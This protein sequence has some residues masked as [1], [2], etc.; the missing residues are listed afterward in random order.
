M[1]MELVPDSDPADGKSL[2]RALLV[3]QWEIYLLRL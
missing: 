3:C 1:A 2:Y